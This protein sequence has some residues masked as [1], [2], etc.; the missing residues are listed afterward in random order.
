MLVTNTKEIGSILGAIH[1]AQEMLGGA[2]NIPNAIEKALLALKHRSNKNLRQRVVVFVGSPLEDH[3]ADEK[4]MIKLAKRLKKN[5]VAVDFV[6]F[7]D[8]IEEGERSILKTF[9]DNVKSNDNW[10]VLVNSIC[11]G[12]VYGSTY[13]G[14]RVQPLSRHTTRRTSIVRHDPLVPHPRRRP[15]YTRRSHG[16]CRCTGR[17]RRRFRVRR[18][19]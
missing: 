6:A 9:V 4:F 1:E 3:A 7:G 18:R 12:L 2:A 13:P 19:P 17:R 10:S 15:W 11:V 8:G 5:N 14:L 16:R